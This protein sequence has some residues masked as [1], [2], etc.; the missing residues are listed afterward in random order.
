[1][2]DWRMMIVNDNNRPPWWVWLLFAAILI[3]LVLL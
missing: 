3:A 2:E 1:M